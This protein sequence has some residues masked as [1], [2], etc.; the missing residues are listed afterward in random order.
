MKR[1]VKS[2]DGN[3]LF[4]NKHMFLFL[5]YSCVSQNQCEIMALLG[6]RRQCVLY[7]TIYFIGIILV[8][9]IYYI[10]ILLYTSFVRWRPWSTS[11]TV[12]REKTNNTIDGVCKI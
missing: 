1:I 3:F 7:N 2:T 4:R 5:P 10:V 8:Y 9:Y 11:K 12:R 6:H